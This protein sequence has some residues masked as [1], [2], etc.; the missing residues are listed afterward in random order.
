MPITKTKIATEMN[1]IFSAKNI[2]AKKNP[3]GGFELPSADFFERF[4]REQKS[5]G[6]LC[7]A[8]FETPQNYAA[9]LTKDSQTEN[10]QT[11][12]TSHEFDFVPL[13]EFCFE[14]EI[15]ANENLSRLALRAKGIVSW[16]DTYRH[17]PKCGAPFSD[18]ESCTSLFCEKCGF[19]L[20]P[21]IEPCVIVIIHRGD[22]I[23]L[24]HNKHFGAKFFSHISGFVELGESAEEAVAREALEEVGITLK[25]IKPLSTQSWPF[26]D[27][28]MLAYSAEYASGELVL[29][30][31]EIAEARFFRRDELLELGE[32]LLPGRGSVAWKMLFGFKHGRN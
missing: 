20:F 7:D 18:D 8:I 32:D 12:S 6:S 4:V 19:R 3:Q 14:N 23:L 15:A 2:L 13:R 16:H 31:E 29:Q 5:Q 22:E 26:P 21:R 9:A 11:H 10:P 25:N 24:V 30:E 28:L 27:Q 1:F 17:C